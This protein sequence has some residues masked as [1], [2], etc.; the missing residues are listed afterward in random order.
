MTRAA[1]RW[2]LLASLVVLLL[3]SLSSLLVV[4]GGLGPIGKRESPVYQQ[5]GQVAAT[6]GLNAH[7]TMRTIA[8]QLCRRTS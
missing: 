6:E 5:G 1:F 3:A 8:R 7:V 2:L 4:A